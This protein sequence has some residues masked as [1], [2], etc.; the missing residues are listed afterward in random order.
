MNDL[1]IAMTVIGS[2][3]TI[4][5]VT[6]AILTFANKK[7]DAKSDINVRLAKIESD[8][9]WIRQH[10]EEDKE[11]KLNVDKRLAKLERREND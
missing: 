9:A 11:W 4:L 6:F 2:I 1:S 10:Q 8:I 5:S 7:S 3:A